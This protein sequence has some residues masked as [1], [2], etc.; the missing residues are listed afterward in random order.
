VN[1][2]AKS[3]RTYFTAPADKTFR[4]AVERAGLAGDVI[5]KSSLGASRRR[6]YRMRRW[7][8][9]M[10]SRLPLSNTHRAELP[11]PA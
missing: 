6:R 8:L 7:S 10:A 5:G 2:G 11:S 3:V 1:L 4:W 9:L